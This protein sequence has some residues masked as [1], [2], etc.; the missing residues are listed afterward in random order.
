MKLKCFFEIV[1]EI[2]VL[3]T[4]HLNF[5][6]RRPSVRFYFERPETYFWYLKPDGDSGS[7]VRDISSSQEHRVS[8]SD[9]APRNF[10][11]IFNAKS[12]CLIQ[13][14]PATYK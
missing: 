6:N 4:L 2:V 8:A 3:I 12:N 9:V 11:Q 10:Q 1:C 13:E 5:K 7:A 14:S